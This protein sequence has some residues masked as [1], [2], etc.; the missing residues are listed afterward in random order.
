MR[1][2]IGQ[3][4]LVERQAIH[5]R[6]A[7]VRSRVAF[8]GSGVDASGRAASC[9]VAAEAPEDPISP[10]CPRLNDELAII[11]NNF[12]F[13]W[14]LLILGQ[15]LSRQW[16]P[17]YLYPPSKSETIGHGPPQ[18]LVNISDSSR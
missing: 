4:A 1:R 18:A 15:K 14:V 5:H 9:Y 11:C 2:F 17:L 8:S 12:V 13:V 6:L 10:A 3:Q 7:A 16:G